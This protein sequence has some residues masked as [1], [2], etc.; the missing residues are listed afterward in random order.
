MNLSCPPVP[1]TDVPALIVIVSVVVAPIPK[2]APYIGS[3]ALG[4][5]WNDA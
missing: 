3:D 1:F 2:T 4:Y 5:A